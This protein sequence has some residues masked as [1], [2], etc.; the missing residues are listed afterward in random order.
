M[1]NMK[2][3]NLDELEGVGGGKGGSKEILP[4]KEGFICYQIEKGD[5]LGKLAKRFH[6]TVAKILDAKYWPHP[7]RK[8]HQQGT[9][10][11]HPLLSRFPIFYPPEP[12]IF[13][14]SLFL[15]RPVF[16]PGGQSG[17]APPVPESLPESSP[18]SAFP[19]P[20]RRR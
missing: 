8:R 3:L 11:L 2:E 17:A 1:D 4:R 16:R 18:G 10:H 19:C 9:L 7:Q 13:R 5:T 14:G 20:A 15:F 12:R 6:T